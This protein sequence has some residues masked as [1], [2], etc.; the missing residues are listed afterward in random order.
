MYANEIATL[1]S[2]ITTLE[3]E[4]KEA[5]DTELRLFLPV[6]LYR[7]VRRADCRSFAGCSQSS[8]LQVRP[9]PGGDFRSW[10]QGLVE[11]CMRFRHLLK[12]MRFESSE[13]LASRILSCKVL[14]LLL[15]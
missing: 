14:P 6:P 11:P 3:T 2:E 12:E 4:L 7:C 9:F 1:D 15:S 8:P 5:A 10:I 13:T